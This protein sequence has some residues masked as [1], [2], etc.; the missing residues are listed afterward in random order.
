MSEETEFTGTVNGQAKVVDIYLEG[1][2]GGAVLA[3]QFDRPVEVKGQNF[4]F[5]LS[6][7]N[8]NRLAKFCQTMIANDLMAKII[9]KPIRQKR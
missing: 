8:C 5:M 3:I 2:S 1:A 4:G 7:R 6:V 9:S